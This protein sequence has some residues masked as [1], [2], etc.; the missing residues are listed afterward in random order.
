MK[1]RDFKDWINKLSEDELDKDLMY[2]SIDYG[3]SGNV[4][5]IIKSEH[6]LYYVGD[7]P[8]LLHTREEL[9]K[10]GFTEPDIAQFEIEIPE[11]CY[12]I[13]ISNEYSILERFLQ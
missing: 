12:Y 2:N 5:E 6:N 10:R 13:E 7:E 1:L 3:I 9:L 11:G 4:N 8:V